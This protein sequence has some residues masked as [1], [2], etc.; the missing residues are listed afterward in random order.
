VDLAFLNIITI[1]D[2]DPETV[3]Q[4]LEKFMAWKELLNNYI[5]ISALLKQLAYFPLV[6]V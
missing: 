3:T 2:V 5:I 6:I 1:P 4:I